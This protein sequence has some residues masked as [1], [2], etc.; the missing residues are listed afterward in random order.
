MVLLKIEVLAEVP[1]SELTP[2]LQPILNS[3]E[4]QVLTT[5]KTKVMEFAHCM[6]RSLTE[7]NAIYYWILVFLAISLISVPTCRIY[8]YLVKS[9]VDN[10]PFMI[11]LRRA[12][13]EAYI[14]YTLRMK[15]NRKKRSLY[16]IRMADSSYLKIHRGNQGCSKGRRETLNMKRDRITQ[17]KLDTE[18]NT[19]QMS[20][21]RQEQTDSQCLEDSKSQC[22]DSET[23]T[24]QRPSQSLVQVHNKE[25]DNIVL[26]TKVSADTNKN[27]IVQTKIHTSEG[28]V[29]IPGD[30][31]VSK[32]NLDNNKA[33]SRIP[34]RKKT[35][36][37]PV[38]RCAKMN[39]EGLPYMNVRA[40]VHIDVIDGSQVRKYNHNLDT[41]KMQTK[42]PVR[43]F[44]VPR[45]GETHVSQRNGE[46]DNIIV[47]TMILINGNT[48]QVSGDKQANMQKQFLDRSRFRSKIPIRANR[49]QGP[50]DSQM[51]IAKGG[52]VCSNRDTEIDTMKKT[53]ESHVR[54]YDRTEIPIRVRIIQVPA[55]RR[56]KINKEG[57]VYNNVQ[58]NRDTEV[59]KIDENHVRKYDRSKIPIRANMIQVP[60]E[61]HVKINKQGLVYRKVQANLDTDESQV[62]K[63]NH[64]LDTSK[65]QTKI[66][67]RRFNTPRPGETLVSQRNGELDNIIVETMI[68]ING[69]TIQVSGDKQGNMQKQFLD[70]SRFRSKIPIRANRIQGPVDS[71]MQIAKG[72]LVCSN[73]DT[74]VDTIKKID[75]SNVRKYDQSKMPMRA[76]LFQVP[77]EIYV[78]IKKKGMV[79]NNVQVSLDS[80]I[81]TV[82]KIDE[83]HVRKYERSK[84]PIRAKIIQAPL[85]RHVKTNEKGLVYSNVQAK[86]DTEIN[87]MLKID[88]SYV[89]KHNRNLETSTRT[90]SLVKSSSIN[91][92]GN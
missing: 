5:A 8:S 57:M 42:I 26:E 29:Q 76:R 7:N 30:T 56:A 55:E 71:Q 4:I 81:K 80:K 88:E 12:G 90:S 78:K 75:E 39:K 36:E 82:E 49:I 61:R 54:K 9:L 59:E 1:T 69:N 65:M 41:S 48:I 21:E 73:R 25:L 72:G 50:V 45:P 62:Q 70:K 31:R 11:A 85:E 84:I 87:T 37:V 58:A 43:S 63:H 24:I 28:T 35:N 60:V 46:L 18:R 34:I 67:V 23:G 13:N 15:R 77:V 38:K 51:Q 3:A 64:N 91:R 83:S 14:K 27:N 68:L 10:W 89:R 52:L 74:E 20:A 92:M 66:P 40:I 53:D 16:P 86:L 79:Y 44:N 22:K 17:D 32:K 2:A 47:E 19:I 33:R 6:R